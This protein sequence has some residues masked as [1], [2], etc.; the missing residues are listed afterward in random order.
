MRDIK[1]IFV[2]CTAGSQKQTK[3][4]LLNEF[5]AK[6][7]TNPGYHYVVFPN[8]TIEQLLPEK[9][10]SNGVQ[11][12]NSTSINV[13]YVG[14]IDKSGKAVD[15]RTAQQKAALIKILTELKTRYPNAVILGH[16]DVWGDDPRNWKKQCP[17]FYAKNEYAGITGS[18]SG[19]YDDATGID[20]AGNHDDT[21]AKPEQFVY[22][23]HTDYTGFL[24]DL[25]P[26][27][28]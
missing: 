4:D 14:G 13:A 24:K 20:E 22:N 3:Q 28:K 23:N 18:V 5:K 12:Y 10:V 21:P 6:G 17:C 27:R 16:R 8:G 7:W 2:H 26:W 19:K 1:R 11:G 25:A 9:E 15:N